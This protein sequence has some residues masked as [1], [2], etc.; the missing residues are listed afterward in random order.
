MYGFPGMRR[1]YRGAVINPD[2]ND[3]INKK[4]I[5]N[6]QN[7]K[8]RRFRKTQRRKKILKEKRRREAEGV[9]LAWKSLEKALIQESHNDI[10]YTQLDEE[11]SSRMLKSY[12]NWIRST[13][14]L[15]PRSKLRDI[16]EIT[17]EYMDMNEYFNN[18]KRADDFFNN[19]TKK[20]YNVPF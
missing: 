4:W 12:D 8:N 6:K 13:N 14:P 3:A 1:T 7:E 18:G 16:G 2:D 9:K 5:K 10:I 17:R 15:A 20:Y 19:E 11:F